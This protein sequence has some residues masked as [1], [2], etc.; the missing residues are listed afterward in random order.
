MTHYRK[1]PKCG[2]VEPVAWSSSYYDREKEIADIDEFKLQMPELGEKLVAGGPHIIAFD[3]VYRI[4]KQRKGYSPTKVDRLPVAIYK[5]RGGTFS[6][7]KSGYY[8]AAADRFQHSNP[9]TK[10]TF[11]G[12]NK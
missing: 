5:A 11:R 3:Y 9:S 8:D 4:A 1:C 7:P 10:T 2:Y 6:K 12:E